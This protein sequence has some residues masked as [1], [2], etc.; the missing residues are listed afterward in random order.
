MKK[1][2]DVTNLILLDLRSDQPTYNRAALV[3][4]CHKP[5]F[6]GFEVWPFG[7]NP[8]ILKRSC[9]KP[10]FVGF[11]VWPW[12]FATRPLLVECHKPYF[13]GF[14]VWPFFCSSFYF[15]NEDVTNLILLDLRSD[16][17]NSEAW[18]KNSNVTNLILL[19]LRSDPILETSK[20][21]Y[22][23]SHKPYFVGFEVWPFYRKGLPWN[24]WCHKPYFV[25]FEVWP[26]PWSWVRRNLYYVTNLIL[27]DLR[28][29]QFKK[30][31]GK[32]YH[33]NV[34]NLILL[35][36][37]SDQKGERL[38]RLECPDVTNLILLDLR[39]DPSEVGPP[40]LVP[41]VTNLILL[42]LRSDPIKNGYAY[43][44]NGMSQTLFCWIWG[45]T[46]KNF[47][48]TVLVIA[49]CHKPYFVGFEVWPNNCPRS[50][51][52]HAKVTNLILLDL[53]SDLYH[54]H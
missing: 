22:R 40:I 7:L 45:L 14:E 10:Y 48:R 20:R 29:D 5:Y 23:K 52:N 49:C 6:V 28:S 25:G 50:P 4:A 17:E 46:F 9:H 32:D 47:C 34:T 31:T 26:H 8:H 18:A 27:L 13:V 33:D 2:F 21:R 1:A 51:D 53:R 19:D 42:D 24:S 16:A 36:L 35:D 37:R 3:F 38:W 30:L 12:K 54:S 11:E 39:S 43:F 15:W 44:G 41:H